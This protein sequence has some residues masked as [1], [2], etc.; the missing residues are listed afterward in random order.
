MSEG[1][2]FH[3]GDWVQV[4]KDLGSSM[5]HFESDCEAIV[6][7]SYSVQYGGADHYSFTIFIKGG[8]HVSWYDERQLTLI[9]A[10][11]L[12]LLEQWE[13]ERAT[14]IKETSDLDWIFSHG[15]DVIDHAHGSSIAA[16]ASCFG[17]TNMWGSH[18][19]GYV[20]HQNAIGTMALALPYLKAGDKA[21][22]LALCDVL[23]QR[24]EK[25]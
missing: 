3:K 15:Q 10:N 24:K 13:I 14:K 9:E 2:K 21:G 6:M 17:L 19:E 22:W 8:G 18:G 7:G 4:A 25:S 11:R 1:Q 16:L 5:N 23:K 12:D 20:W